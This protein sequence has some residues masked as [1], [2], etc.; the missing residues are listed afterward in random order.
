MIKAPRFLPQAPTK[1]PDSTEQ[2]KFYRS[3][4]D[5][6]NSARA[7]ITELQSTKRDDIN[8]PGTALGKGASAP[9]LVTAYGSG[10]IQVLAFDG[11][12]TTEQLYASGE[13]LHGY[14]A[15]TDISFH[16]HWMPTTADTGTVKW[17]LEYVWQGLEETGTPQ[18]ISTTG[19]A[20]GAW[21]HKL[22]V[23]PEIPGDGKTSGSQL[24]FRFYRDP[25]QDTYAADAAILSLGIHYQLNKHGTDTISGIG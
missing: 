17:N 14:V 3:V 7:D 19:D 24:S 8:F 10:G 16:V 25:S 5:E 18:T 13:I 23:F 9:G 11:G 15:G 22:A 4:A 1:A 2:E 20:D 6:A 21:K 12:A